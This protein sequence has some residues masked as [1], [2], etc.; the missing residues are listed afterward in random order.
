MPQSF[1]TVENWADYTFG[2]P[3]G[4][5]TPQL[6]NK[7]WGKGKV[8]NLILYF[9]EIGTDNKYWLSIFWDNGYCADDEALSFRNVEP[10]S[11]L[12]LTTAKTKTGKPCSRACGPAR[13]PVLSNSI[14][15]RRKCLGRR[16]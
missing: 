13:S 5:W 9:S 8:G 14:R 2:C 1:R 4:K 3:E 10:G 11:V 7:S 15:Q 12:E 6:D 16:C